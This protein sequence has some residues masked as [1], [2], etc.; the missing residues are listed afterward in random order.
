MSPEILPPISALRRITQSLAMLDAIICPEWEYRY[1]SFNSQWGPG[2]EM[3]S[4][5][6]G[7]GDDWF[8][9]FD[10]AGAAIKGFAH[11]L[12]D[13]PA[14]AQNIQAQVPPDFASFLNEPAFSMQNATFCYWRKSTDTA[15]TKVKST[16]SEDGTEMLELIVSGPMGYKTWAEDYYELSV[17]LDAVEALFS[18]QPLDESL[19]LALNP[20]A[21][22]NM[23]LADANEIGYPHISS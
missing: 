5:R 15:W 19:V 17:S 14:L 10:S 11:E 3:A 8:L 7:S 12:N 13:D 16:L 18:H 22:L 20:D 6:N 2:E 4:M 23:V 21:D 9:L 1:Y